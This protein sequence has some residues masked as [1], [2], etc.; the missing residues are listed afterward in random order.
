MVASPAT[1]PVTIP[2]SDGF[3]NLIHSIIIHDNA[4]NDAAICVTKTAIDAVESAAKAEPPLKPN[5][6][7]HNMQAPIIVIT[8]LCGGLTEFS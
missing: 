2:T 4:P 1:I 6:P 7:T 8:G 3:P 5:Q